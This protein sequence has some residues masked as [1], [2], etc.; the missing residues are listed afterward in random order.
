M[1]LSRSM[2]SSG[3]W[4]TALMLTVPL[5]PLVWGSMSWGASM[6]PGSLGYSITRTAPDHRPAVAG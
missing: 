5:M 4:M 2:E 6:G 1:V 3:L